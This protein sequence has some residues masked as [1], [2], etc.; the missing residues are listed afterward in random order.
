MIEHKPFD[1]YVVN[2]HSLHNGHL[3]RRALPRSSTAP[4]PFIN[5]DEHQAEHAKLSAELRGNPK[6][7]T[8]RQQAREKKQAEEAAKETKGKKRGKKRSA[9]GALKEEGEP[10]PKLED[11][12]EE[13]VLVSELGMLPPFLTG[14]C[15]NM[16]DG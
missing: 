12:K 14:I 7:H 15:E 4:T 2:T 13:M 3:L 8:S 5:P 9:N 16:D 10:L 1:V 6:S 11:V